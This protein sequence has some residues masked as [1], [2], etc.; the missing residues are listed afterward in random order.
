[1]NYT[2]NFHLPQWASSDRILM[3]DFNAMCANIDAGLAAN[4]QA[5]ASN[6]KAAEAARSA[7][8]AAQSKAS[9]AFDRAVLPRFHAGYYTGNGST[10]E[11]VYGYRPIFV[12]IYG[13]NST[14]ELDEAQNHMQYFFM[15]GGEKV[16][17]QFEITDQGFNIYNDSSRTR[18]PILNEKGRRYEYIIFR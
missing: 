15:G 3:N 17:Y 10:L 5:A 8:A 11:I 9:T 18:Y 12:I 13:A 6:A 7:A 1:M 16:L 4:A 14:T 2:E